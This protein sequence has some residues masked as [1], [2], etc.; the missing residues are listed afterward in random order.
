MLSLFSRRDPNDA[1]P[2]DDPALLLLLPRC[3]VLDQD[4]DEDRASITNVSKEHSFF[5]HLL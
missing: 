3:E 4:R 2:I 5:S 1:T